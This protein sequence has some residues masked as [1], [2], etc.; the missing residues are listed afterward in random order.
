MQIGDDVKSLVN[1]DPLKKGDQGT[2]TDI[3]RLLPYP[4]TVY[5][6]SVKTSF[7][8]KESELK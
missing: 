4:I 6:T 7:P 8:M 5:F 2:V 1:R 3:N